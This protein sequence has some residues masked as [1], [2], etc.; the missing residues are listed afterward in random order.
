[1]GHGFYIYNHISMRT[2]ACLQGDS[3]IPQLPWTFALKLKSDGCDV[4]N[5]LFASTVLC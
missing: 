4:R 2:L 5:T 1:M 3:I